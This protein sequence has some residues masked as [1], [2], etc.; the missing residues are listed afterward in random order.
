MTFNIVV[1]TPRLA[2]AGM[3]LLKSSDC[4]AIFT[5]TP[6]RDEE[7]IG[8]LN[9]EPIDA[10]ISRTMRLSGTAIRSCPT[11]KVI[12]RHGIG[13]NHI[14][15]AT[16]TQRGIPVLTTP[17]ANSHAVAELTIGLLL[18][19]ARSIPCHDNAIRS[20]NWDRTLAGRQLSGRTLGIVGLG[21]IGRLVAKA[22]IGLGMRVVAYRGSPGTELEALSVTMLSSLDELLQQSDVLSPHC[23]LD[24]KTLGMIGR[25]EIGLLPRGAIVINTSRGALVD[26]SALIEALR[27]GRL[28]GAGLDTFITEPLPRE[29]VLNTIPNVVMI[30]HMGASTD[31]ALNL[32]AHSVVANALRYLRGEPIDPAICVNPSTLNVPT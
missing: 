6:D 11:L 2:A 16:A 14:D 23:P 27:D 26:E 15:V 12:S 10:I 22:A 25:R 9:R 32:T 28:F 5:S 4:N 13:V 21:V 31:T 3:D 29:H 1:T 24:D 8:I 19:V 17:G 30:P 18:A 7:L 20:G